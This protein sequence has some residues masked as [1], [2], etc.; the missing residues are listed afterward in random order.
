LGLSPLRPTFLDDLSAARQDAYGRVGGDAVS[1]LPTRC[2]VVVRS[3]LLARL[4]PPYDEPPDAD[5]WEDEDE[6]DEEE[7]E[8]EGDEEDEEEP[9]WYVGR[10]RSGLTCP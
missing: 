4:S 5:G 8:D 10:G 2:P 1:R 3:G 6:N 9:E 7:D